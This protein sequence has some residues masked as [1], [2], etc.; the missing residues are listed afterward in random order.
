MRLWCVSLML[1]GG[2]ALGTAPA[3]AD[4]GGDFRDW[5]QGVR[6]EAQ[7][8]GVGEAAVGLIAGVR[9]NP[10]VLARDRSQQV[11]S[12]DW[13]TFAGRMVNA[14]RLKSG[15]SY[16]KQLAGPFAAAQQAFGVPGPVIAAFW[17][18][19]TDFGK[20]QGD[21]STLDAL[22]TL[23][24]DCRRPDLFRPQLLAAL[25]L[26]DRGYLTPA[27]LT[28]AWAGELGQIQLLPAD[29][30]AFGTDGDGDGRVDLRSSAADVILT[31]ARFLQ[32]LGWRAGEPWLEEVRIPDGLPWGQAGL[33]VP[34]RQWADWGVLAVS[35]APLADTD[36][37]TAELPASLLL[38]M[39]SKGPAF[40][41]YPNFACIMRWNH[42]RVYATTV[43]YLANRLA[44]A[45]AAQRGHPDP[46]LSVEQLK[47][48]QEAL[49]ALGDDIGAA[50]GV[51]G[52][53]TRE[54]V[55]REQLRRGLPADGWPTMELL[56]ARP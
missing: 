52:T 40:L 42:S 53:K 16:L 23:A 13:Q 2:G 29:Y 54:A 28:G 46:A 10:K 33:A 11:F 3:G 4:C 48:L 49:L 55:R 22:A 43:A 5:L 50:D 27:Q 1:V 34:R 32:H 47:Q 7:A 15:R 45:P 44:G 6:A 19:E 24:H 9:E 39:G 31:G 56:T 17:G 8:S 51:L 36:P 41:T 12:Q 26:V 18:L 37:S 30:L 38:P 20:V 35:G 25:A 21:F 14:F